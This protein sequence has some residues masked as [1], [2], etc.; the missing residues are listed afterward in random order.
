MKL[1]LEVCRVFQ[2]RIQCFF[3]VNYLN[4][5]RKEILQ[6]L[7]VYVVFTLGTSAVTVEMFVMFEH[8]AV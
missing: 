3:I 2:T 1:F 4:G 8:P 6:T 5:C 7:N